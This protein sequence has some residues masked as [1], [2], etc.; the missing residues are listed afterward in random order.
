MRLLVRVRA[1]ISSMRAPLRPSRANASVATSMMSAMVRAATEPARRPRA[2]DVLL[3]CLCATLGTWAAIIHGRLGPVRLAAP[4]T[5]AWAVHR[6]TGARDPDRCEA[7]RRAGAGP[8][9]PLRARSPR[10]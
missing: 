9:A 4:A 7:P 8:A 2:E 10:R 1:A 3:G 6:G 5:R